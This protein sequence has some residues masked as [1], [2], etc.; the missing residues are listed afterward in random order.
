MNHQ[1]Y[2]FLG[3]MVCVCLLG[4]CANDFGES[5]FE[6][7]EQAVNQYVSENNLVGQKTQNGVF[8]ALQESGNGTPVRAND[9][10][11]LDYQLYL[12]SGEAFLANDNYVY[13]PQVGAFIY[14]LTEGVMQ[15]SEGEKAIFVIPSLVAFG[16]QSFSVGDLTIPSHT[17]LIAKVELKE[18]RTDTQ[19]LEIESAQIEQVLSEKNLTW[20]KTKEGLYFVQLEASTNE[21]RPENG[22]FVMVDYEGTLLD[23]RRFDGGKSFGFEVGTDQIIE[24]WNVG[25][26]RMTRG[27]TALWLMPSAL[28]YQDRGSGGEIAPFTPLVFEVTLQSITE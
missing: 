21:I 19:Q 18:L 9:I 16:A 12:P 24:G 10:V 11:V 17:I 7:D 26:R 3:I 15:M 25:I 4:A 14:G 2:A 28:A 22:Q 5:L 1:F 8:Y 27:E 20:E 6:K 13:R 23:G